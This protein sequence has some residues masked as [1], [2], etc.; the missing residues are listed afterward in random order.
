MVWR[1][2]VTPRGRSWWAL[3]TAGPSTDESA[4]GSSPTDSAEWP[5]PTATSYGSNQG[6]ANPDG[7]PRPSLEGAARLIAAGKDRV[8]P[9][10]KKQAKPK[11]ARLWPTATAMDGNSSG[12]ATLSTESGRH[13]GT[14]LT[15]AARGRWATP[16]SRDEKS[17]SVSE[18]TLSKRGTHRRPLGEQVVSL[19]KRK[20]WATPLTSDQEGA[21]LNRAP[22]R[23]DSGGPASNLVDQANRIEIEERKARRQWVTPTATAYGTNQGGANRDGPARPSLEGQARDL[24]RQK[25]EPRS[26]RK[27]KAAASGAIRLFGEESSPLPDSGNGNGNSLDSSRSTPRTPKT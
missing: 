23:T 24:E 1:R 14:T 6:G 26:A 15:D 20:R 9:R 4:C 25:D 17:G 8:E 13:A 22:R 12:C 19:A 27:K 3:T 21:S 5:T 10:A 16:M 18:A 11:A 7:P 2:T